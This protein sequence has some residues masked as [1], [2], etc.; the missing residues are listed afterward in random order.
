MPFA[1]DEIR[2]LGKMGHG[3]VATDTFRTAPGS[4]S[5]Y[6]DDWHLTASPRYERRRFIDQIL[7]I[8]QDDEIDLILPAFEEAFYLAW[9]ID[10]L[11][12]VTHVFLPPFETLARMHD[13]AALLALAESLSLRVPRT[14]L[15]KSRA[16]LKRAIGAYPAYFAR[17]AFSRG[18]V[19][20]LTNTGPLAGLL[21]VD[22]CRPTPHNPWLVQEYVEGEDICTFSIAHHGR[23]T[24]HSTYVH[25]R[26]LEHAGG[27]VFE[28]IR[29]DD[30][31][32]A[33]SEIVRATG[34]HGQI[35]FDFRRT[36]DGV[37]LIECNPRPT[38]GVFMM[39]AH[40]FCDALFDVAPQ[41]TRVAPPGVKL[42]Y[43]TALIRDMVLHWREAPEDLRYL[44]S[45]AK[46]VY[47]ERGDL[48]PAIYQ[49]LS[50]SH[51]A[52]YKWRKPRDQRKP[53]DLAAAYFEDILWNG[54]A[55][56]DEPRRRT[57]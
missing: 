21:S 53:T 22:A 16:E 19:E 18:G 47:A 36:G 45:S 52:A 30:A 43:S 10:E 23:L 1:L 35:S 28:S 7:K 20:L 6:L 12:R 34:Y 50:Y 27:I 3:V 46:D 13:K 25:P 9:H 49:V 17:A 14:T 37:M 8:V 40:D 33:V 5:K 26:E 11:Q 44:M 55:F 56:E 29:D 2:K 41:H 31:H 57:G 48:V 54:E 38:A 42:K 15:A 4:H 24:A 32:H 51:V 39:S